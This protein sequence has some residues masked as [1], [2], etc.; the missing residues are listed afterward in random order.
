MTT[1]R[2]VA[3]SSGNPRGSMAGVAAG[4][5]VGVC[6]GIAVGF[7]VGKELRVGV[8]TTGVMVEVGESGGDDGS[9]SPSPQAAKVARAAIV[10]ASMRIRRIRTLQSK[11]DG[12]SLR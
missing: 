10:P 5:A 11:H 2:L 12:P 7:A 3:G 8:A 6:A 9:L 1:P 4:E